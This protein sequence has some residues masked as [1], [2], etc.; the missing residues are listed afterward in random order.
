[1]PPLVDPL[2]EEE[3]EQRQQ[4]GFGSPSESGSSESFTVVSVDNIVSDGE[5][6]IWP[7]HPRYEPADPRLYLIKL[8]TMW[9]KHLGKEERGQSNQLT[10]VITSRVW[11]LLESI[12]SL[13]CG[14]TQVEFFLFGRSWQMFASSP[15]IDSFLR[16]MPCVWDIRT[17][18]FFERS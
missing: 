14:Y 9:M 4:Q 16:T 13:V 2:E 12:W 7:T 1:M 5:R 11:N 15:D 17:A 18:T 6:G 3:E 10:L 8:A